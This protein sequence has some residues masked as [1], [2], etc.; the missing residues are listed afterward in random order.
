MNVDPEKSL[1]AAIILKAYADYRW[2]WIYKL[3]GVEKEDFNLAELEEFFNSQW[4][5]ELCEI[6]KMPPQAIREKVEK[7][8]RHY[9]KRIQS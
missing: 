7:V 5:E 2:A 4:F 6:V 8:R 9:E 1:A 3:R